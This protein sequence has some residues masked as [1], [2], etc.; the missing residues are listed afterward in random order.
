MKK[1]KQ[2][3]LSEEEEIAQVYTNRKKKDKCVK[4]YE[5]YRKS[6]WKG[7][8]DRCGKKRGYKNIQNLFTSETWEIWY[9]K[10]EILIRNLL[11]QNITPSIERVDSKKDYS[12][13]NCI[14]LPANL[15]STLGRIHS[16]KKQLKI[17]QKYVE[18]NLHFFPDEL[19]EYYKQEY[20]K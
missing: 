17:F 13:E 3:I 2:K 6:M 9:N 12:P 1:S 11:Q 7:I 18:N 20:L 4:T 10:N 14:I 19:R 8:V 15:N 5:H 16:A